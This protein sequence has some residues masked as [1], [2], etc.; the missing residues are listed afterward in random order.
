MTQAITALMGLR[1]GG[2]L[3]VG[4][5][6]GQ[7]LL[8]VASIDREIAY[9][10]F[11][12]NPACADYVLTLVAANNLPFAIVPAGLGPR[13][14]VLELQIFR[15]EDTDPSASL[16]PGFRDGLVRTR[17]VVVIGLADLPEGLIPDPLALIKID[18]EG[19]ELA[20]LEGL[21][22]ILASQRPCILI[23]ILPAY[24]AGNLARLDRQ[25]KVQGI[26]LRAAYT[27]FRI[28]KTSGDLLAGI[29]KIAEIGIHGDLALADYLMVPAEDEE[30]VSA[31]FAKLN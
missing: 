15:D 28:R 12:P 14:E 8:K 13:T 24:D 17:P 19:G 1:P 16:V 20:V 4:V 27:M 30:R 26:L 2:F 23:E 6:L 25:S 18:V 11:E 10:G 31:A 3:D 7:T 21:A 22:P 9:L 5:N 29:E